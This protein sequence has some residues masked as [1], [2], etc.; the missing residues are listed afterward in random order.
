MQAFYPHNLNQPYP[1]FVKQASM[2]VSTDHFRT[3]FNKTAQR[4]TLQH[5]IT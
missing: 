4:F 1:I 3:A 5:T 2:P